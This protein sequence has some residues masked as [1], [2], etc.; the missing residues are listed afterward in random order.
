[1]RVAELYI[2]KWGKLLMNPKKSVYFEQL[3]N[4]NTRAYNELAELLESAGLG[5][6]KLLAFVEKTERLYQFY[7]EE[8][9][10]S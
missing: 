5:T 4:E 2:M 8:N 3:W 1:M 7:L 9:Y 6:A 10:P